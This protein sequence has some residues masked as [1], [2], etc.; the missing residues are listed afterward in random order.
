MKGIL[1]YI[2]FFGSELDLTHV[3]RSKDATIIIQYINI[4][5]LST[6]NIVNIKTLKCLAAVMTCMI[7]RMHLGCS[8]F[9]MYLYI[10]YMIYSFVVSV[11]TLQLGSNLF[12]IHHHRNTL[13]D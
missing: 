6:I 12:P 4:K 8:S 2:L 10:Q 3:A 9:N 13:Q 1:E 7:I 5:V 11:T